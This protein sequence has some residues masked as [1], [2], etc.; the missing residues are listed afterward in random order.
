MRTRESAVASTQQNLAV[1]RP[2][3]DRRVEVRSVVC[4]QCEAAVGEPCM[5]RAGKVVH[6]VARRRDAL[7]SGA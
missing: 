7:R 2:F 3:R 5:S 1:F 6:H 4:R